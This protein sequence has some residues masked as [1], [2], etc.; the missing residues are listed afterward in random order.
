M[1]NETPYEKNHLQSSM[2][3][4]DM[5]YNPENTLLIKDAPAARVAR[6]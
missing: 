3:V 2:V 5:V 6:W 4:F 1:S